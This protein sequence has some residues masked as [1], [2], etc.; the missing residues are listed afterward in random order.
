MKQ[1]Y[2]LVKSIQVIMVMTI[3]NIT[4]ILARRLKKAIDIIQIKSKV[5]TKL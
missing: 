2:L 5:V 3:Y 1:I 4:K